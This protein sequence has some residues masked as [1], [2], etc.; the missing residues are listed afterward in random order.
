MCDGTPFLVG[1]QIENGNM[2]NICD[3]V[4]KIIM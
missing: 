1:D 3:L 2:S 4:I